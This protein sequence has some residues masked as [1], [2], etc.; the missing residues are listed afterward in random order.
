MA[1]RPSASARDEER[2]ELAEQTGYTKPNHDLEI[3][4][5]GKVGQGCGGK[6]FD[7]N[8][9]SHMIF[10]CNMRGATDATLY[11]HTHTHTKQPCCIQHSCYVSVCVF[12]GSIEVDDLQGEFGVE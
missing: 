12:A 5:N 1:A 8:D 10:A 9:Y 11:K 2:L 7:P 3:N 4:K 6:H